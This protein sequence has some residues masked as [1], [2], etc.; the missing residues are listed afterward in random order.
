[1]MTRISL[2]T[3]GCLW[4]GTAAAQSGAAGFFN[5]LS[6]SRDGIHLDGVSIYGSY[7]SGGIPFEMASSS[8]FLAPG[9]QA[10]GG[11]SIRLGLSRTR[12]DSSLAITYSPSFIASPDY[13]NVNLINSSFSLNWHRKVGQKSSVD[14]GIT[15]LVSDLQQTYFSANAFGQAASL[16]TTFDGLAAAM[17]S[18]TFTDSQLASALTGASA[19]MTPEQTYLYGARFLSATVRAGF[20]YAPTGRSSFHASVFATRVQHLGSGQTT[21][22]EVPAII[23]QTTSGGASLGWAYALSP[24]THIG[25]EASTTRTFSRVQNSYASTAAFSIGRTI[26]EHFFV[27]GR[28]GG[29]LTTYLHQTIA[30]PSNIPYTAGGSIGYKMHAHTLIAS[31]DRSLADSYGLG[32]TSTDSALAGWT[33]KAP[34]SL[35]SLSANYGYQRLNGGLVIRNESWRATGGIARALNG[36]VFMSLQYAYFTAPAYLSASANLTEPENALILGLS[37]SPS[38]YR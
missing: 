10:V 33:W 20:S 11:G 27:Q 3:L 2:L 16:P 32:S 1:M 38:P 22:G 17:L 21:D 12:E 30:T 7:F 28:V 6:A 15:A 36:H 26:S 24:R 25:L 13:T 14:T 35:W 34:G 18:G 4:A 19:R 31:F 37:W 5:P 8:N 29:G 23:P 9:A